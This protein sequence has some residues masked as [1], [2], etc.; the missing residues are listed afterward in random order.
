MSD[1]ARGTCPGRMIEFQFPSP[2]IDFE[3]ISTCKSWDFR[4]RR[5]ESPLNWTLIAFQVEQFRKLSSSSSSLLV[6]SAENFVFPS[7]FRL[8]WESDTRAGSSSS[9]SLAFGAKPHRRSKATVKLIMLKFIAIPPRTPFCAHE[10]DEVWCGKIT[11][12]LQLRIHEK[13]D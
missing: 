4:Q 10:Q 9:Q 13:F 12:L 11:L 6:Q 8:R 2:D 3:E 5:E 7:S 1:E